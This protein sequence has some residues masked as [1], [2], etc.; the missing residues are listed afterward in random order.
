M[1]SERK[2][3]TFRL[4]P[5]ARCGRNCA[6][7]TMAVSILSMWVFRVGFCY[8]MVLGF[9]GRLLSIWMGMFLDWVFRSLCFFVRFARGRWMEQS[10]I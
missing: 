3:I 7:F 5:P 10:V 6:R 8:V 2:R 1:R 9:H 4:F